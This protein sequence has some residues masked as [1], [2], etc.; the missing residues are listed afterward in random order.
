MKS[1]RTKGS[2]PTL[3]PYILL[4]SFRILKRGRAPAGEFP[5]SYDILPTHL[6]LALRLQACQLTR[7]ELPILIP[8]QVMFLPME[9]NILALHLLASTTSK[10]VH[11]MDLCICHTYILR[12]S[13]PRIP[14]HPSCTSSRLRRRLPVPPQ[15]VA[16]RPQV[17]PRAWTRNLT[18]CRVRR[19]WRKPLAF[20]LPLSM[21][22]SLVRVP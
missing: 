20:L 16:G 13:S 11:R 6:A 14:S 2:I 7:K 10:T 4:V 12:F 18:T 5:P 17:I 8:L 3:A 15:A 1:W 22:S 19:L 21:K 9:C